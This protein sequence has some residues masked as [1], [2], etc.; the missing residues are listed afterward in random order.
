MTTDYTDPKVQ[1]QFDAAE[2]SDAL[3]LLKQLSDAG[4]VIPHGPEGLYDYGRALHIVKRWLKRSW[5][6]G[7]KAA[8]GPTGAPPASPDKAG[9][10]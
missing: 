6:E 9:S 1:A 7:W 10:R 8:G 2:T 3:A 4:A 5:S